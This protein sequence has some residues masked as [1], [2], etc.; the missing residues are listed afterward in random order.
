MTVR[1]ILMTAD[2]VGGVWQYA[3]DL[4]AALAD[5]GIETVLA[6][7][8]PALSPGQR[9]AA[10][11]LPG[12]TVVETGLP[13]DWLADDVGALVEAHRAIDA[14][15]VEHVV[16]LIHLNMPALAACGAFS[17]PTVAVAHSCLRTWWDAAGEGEMPAD[18]GWR[19]DLMRRGLLAADRVVT[20]TAAFAAAL[21]QAYHL[22]ALPAVAHNGRKPLPLPE[23]VQ[24]DCVF[25]AGRLWDQGKNIA[26]LDAAAATIEVPFHAAGP[27]EG[28]HGQRIELANL[29][30]LGW[31]DE[32]DLAARLSARPVFASAALYEPFGLAVL[33]AANAGCALVLSDIPTFR[34]LWSGA[35]LFVRPDDAEEFAATIRELV[36]DARTRA[37]I[38]AAARDRAARYTPAATARRMIEIYAGLAETPSARRV[39][40]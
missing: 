2:A 12:T 23:T 15:A 22:P 9:R 29:H 19:L 20:P 3:T 17:L 7:M 1:R 4:A 36:R 26:T 38:G 31:L 40:A 6:T 39:A 34:E 16:D 18:F 25:T 35:A 5:E 8:G 13:L 11:E 27:V 24:H 14:L 33:E 30:P 28:P 32:R 37:Q 21:R 10:A